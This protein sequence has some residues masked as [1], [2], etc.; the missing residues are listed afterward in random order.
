MNDDSCTVV[1]RNNSSNWLREE[2]GILNNIG[3]YNV[4]GEI[5]EIWNTFQHLTFMYIYRLNPF[6]EWPLVF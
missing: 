2:T 4:I 3:H 6:T 1:W 5:Q